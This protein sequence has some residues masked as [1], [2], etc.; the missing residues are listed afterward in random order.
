MNK[1]KNNENMNTEISVIGDKRIDT[2]YFIQHP[3]NWKPP[4]RIV[5]DP[6]P[7]SIRKI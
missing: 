6:R 4:A 7:I 5:R 1:K 2:N 3:Q